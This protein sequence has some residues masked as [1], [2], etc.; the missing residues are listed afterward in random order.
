MPAFDTLK[1]TLI[2]LRKYPCENLQRRYDKISCNKAE[3]DN[4]LKELEINVEIIKQK[5]KTLEIYSSEYNKC[6]TKNIV[7]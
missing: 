5:I 4:K 7:K 3:K 2:Y 1:D 6:V